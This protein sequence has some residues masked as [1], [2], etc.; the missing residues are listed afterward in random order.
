MINLGLRLNKSRV[1]SILDAAMKYRQ[2]QGF[3]EYPPCGINCASGFIRIET[4]GS[5]V[6]QPHARQWRQRHVVRGQWPITE[7]P[8][9]FTNSRLA[10]YLSDAFA[11]DPDAS[12]KIN[13]LG[14]V[15]GCTALGWGTRVR[16]PK[17]IVTYS[18]EGATGKST[19]L[20]LLRSLP[21][22]DAVASVPP[23]KFGDE[24]YA[25]R[26]IGR[27]LNAADEL[28]DRAVR[29]DVFKRMITGEPVPARDVYRSATDFSPVALHVFSTNVLPAF[30][31][32]VDGGT[33]RRLLP[34]EFTHVVPEAG[35][36]PDLPDRIV[37]EEADLFLHFAVEGACRLVRNRD[38]TVPASS[39]ELLARWVLSA[40]PVRAW[41]AARLAVTAEEN[42]ISVTVLFA[43]FR[44]WAEAQ[45]L[46]A[47]FLP[48]V[49]AFGKRL[50][51]AA[52]GL[53]YHR[54]DG[55]AYR[56]ARICAR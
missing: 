21:N 2:Q 25:W 16:N 3:F 14:E 10:R 12:D 42:M 49:I 26:L 7:D 6:L 38:F 9:A 51:S 27:V 8:E 18:E 4:D 39:R 30:S 23:G 56:N 53:E 36:D 33:V 11:N 43:D 55:S 15:A 41:A 13:L 20:R 40:D 45:G 5:A 1:A 37:S 28:P 22:P 50:R 46:K 47:E 31:G 19:Y 54:S 52:P 17:A 34:L 48:S 35:R 29:S 24:K 44:N 32:G